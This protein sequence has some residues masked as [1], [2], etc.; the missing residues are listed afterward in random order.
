V[1]CRFAHAIFCATLFSISLTFLASYFGHV[2]WAKGH[3]W[4]DMAVADMASFILYFAFATANTL[5]P[6]FPDVRMGPSLHQSRQTCPASNV[7]LVFE[8][9]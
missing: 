5:L 9:V 8:D 6:R 4:P 3:P 1:F 2:E 7:F